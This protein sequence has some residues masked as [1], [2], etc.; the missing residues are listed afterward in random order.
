MKPSAF[1]NPGSGML[2]EATKEHERD[3]SNGRYKVMP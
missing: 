3:K 1:Y 2:E